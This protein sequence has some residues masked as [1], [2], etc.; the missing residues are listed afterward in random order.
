MQRT[1]TTS[2][3]S[4]SCLFSLNKVERPFAVIG[5]SA[6]CA[7]IFSVFLDTTVRIA[8]MAFCAVVFVILFIWK[9]REAFRGYLRLS[10][11]LLTVLLA[12]F[13]YELKLRMEI[14]PAAELAEKMAQVEGRVLG[15]PDEQF[16][17]FYYTLE[18]ERVLVEET[19][20][21]I[22]TFRTRM[23]TSTALYCRPGDRIRTEVAFF[24]YPDS[25]GFSSKSSYAAKGISVACYQKSYTAQVLDGYEE[26]IT[27]IFAGLQRELSETVGV[28][29]PGQEAALVQAMLLGDRD[30]ISAEV[31]D[32]FRQSGI[33][34][35]LV[36]SGLHMSMV[37]GFILGFLSL[38]RLP[39][40]VK[41]PLAILATVGFMLLTGLS[42]SVLRSG[43]MMIIFLTAD[44]FG[45][46]A[47]AL[48]SLGIAILVM[49][50]TNP[51]IGGDVGYLLSVFA[52]MGIIVLSGPLQKIL[53]RPFRRL[54]R[55]SSRLNGAASGLAAGIA[56]SLF[57]LPLQ[58]YLFGSISLMGPFATLLMSLPCT[59]MMLMAALSLL[60]FSIPALQLL[61]QPFVYLCGLLCRLILNL[62]DWLSQWTMFS[63]DTHGPYALLPLCG[64]LCLAAV[65]I[66]RKPLRLTKIL[67][68][69]LMA[70]MI[71]LSVLLYDVKYD[72]SVILA[73]PNQGDDSTVVVMKGKEA[74]ILSSGGYNLSVVGGILQ[75]R[76]IHTVSSILIRGDES[77]E[78]GAL[79]S[80]MGRYPV[81][82]V[83]F[84]E[85]FYV[86]RQLK[87]A[88]GD[89][90]FLFYGE[91]LE[92]E[93]LEGLPVEF[94]SPQ[95]MRF[96][97]SGR[98]VFL[99]TGAADGGSSDILLTN[100][101]ESRVNSPFT[102][103]QSDDIII[104][105]REVSSQYLFTCRNYVT[106]LDFLK[107][108]SLQIRGEE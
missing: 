31:D 43:I 75:E 34:H 35:L 30:G 46:E 21:E 29:L 85:E 9:K 94:H 38:L 92:Y 54:P 10:A 49:C 15:Y 97:V 4:V 23:S 52:T 6:L 8:T 7:L 48:S 88:L 93:A 102:V 69:V 108:G 16:G 70:V 98:T 40:K 65:L 53:L 3:S 32:S 80:L 24:A 82:C 68:P 22:G 100:N 107:D 76:D 72:G 50:V 79:Y 105:M 96:T 87:A 60:L 103:M 83:Y 84:P 89:T 27:T 63:L 33:S 1:G 39:K 86:D 28:M 57:I 17:K 61:S 18:V 81:D 19:A 59:A 12:F 74:A 42:V 104:P 25:F 90:P 78:I 58:V 26:S 106:Y 56:A 101:M 44:L 20:L 67:A 11:A 71:L 95:L 91:T 77:D 45:R 14:Q 37:S 2:C 41:N 55:I 47:D 66:L 13:A 62:A 5:I 64:A 99:E 36:V 51:L 73:V